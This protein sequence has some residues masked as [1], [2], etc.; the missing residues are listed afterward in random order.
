MTY[1]TLMTVFRICAV[2][3]GLMSAVTAALFLKLRIAS[4][5]G[6]VTGWAAR[7]AVAEMARRAGK[8]KRP[9]AQDTA[10]CGSSEETAIL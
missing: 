9:A 10:A 6:T 4:A 1:D 2:S 3:A 8:E 7:R 5:I